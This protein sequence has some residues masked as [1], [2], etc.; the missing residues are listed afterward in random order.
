MSRLRVYASAAMLYLA[1]SI[2]LWWGVWTS[3]PSTVTTCGC[4]D[5]A[6][7]LW[8]F[9]WPA[10]A[11]T[12]G[13]SLWFSP[14]LFHPGGINL[15]ND[16]SVLALSVVLTP[17]T[18]LFGPVAAMNVALA[19]APVVSAL[20]MMVLLRRWVTWT[21]A[22]VLGGLLYGFSP[23][24]ITELAYNQLNIGFLAIP[25]LL[26]VA[27]DELLVRQRRSPYLMGA[28]IAGLA[29]VQFFVS[30]EVL[31]IT[32]IAALVVAVLR[33]GWSA[34]GKTASW[35]PRA[36]YAL[37]G[38]ATALVISVAVLA[39]PAWYLLQGP[40]HLTGPIWSNGAIDQFGNSFTSFWIPSGSG[41]LSSQMLRFGGYQGAPLPG[42]G[43]LGG[44]VVAIAVIGAV[45]WRHDRRILLFAGLGVAATALS[46]GPG[47]GH[48][49]PWSVARH[50]PWVGNI[51][52]V[53]FS[54]VTSLCLAVVVALA[55]D[56]SRTWVATRRQPR[57]A[58]RN[59]FGG[60]SVATVTVA[61]VGLASLIPSLVAL[62]PNLPLTT[63]AVVLPDWYQNVG[64]HLPPGQ[65]VLSY[66]APFAGVQ[67]SMAWQA[68][69]HMSYAMAGG[70]GPEGVANRAGGAEAGFEV[71]FGASL[72]LGPPPGPSA[73][74]LAAIRQALTTWQVTMVVVPDQPGLPSYDQGRSPAYAVGLMTAALGRPPHLDHSAWVWSSVGTRTPP[75]AIP[76]GA[77][78][79]EAC[80]TGPAAGS[81]SA[82][83]RRAVVDCV[84]AAAA[85]AGAATGA[86]S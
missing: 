18:L 67:S 78:R 44:G 50:V 1:M 73:A 63:R 42:L 11:F 81:A 30:T 23:F 60:T 32:A 28:A 52:E 57:A 35:R 33:L 61:I 3:H 6:R 24:M 25:P 85:A 75:P 41:P 45:I 34:V 9:E 83:A 62:W 19:L 7:F 68:V 80:T 47:D 26:A 77:G 64:A 69:N 38:S 55:I 13:H 46:L 10:F 65:V 56:K 86:A 84:L 29:V 40:A 21:P 76:M 74:N 12:N 72:A 22:A 54:L 70:G 48:W 58:S 82:T 31:L 16:T 37:R 43:Y 53:R 2:G 15:L 59:W 8:F 39:Y 66:P 51:V 79:F 20:A 71:L 27:L 36:G 14:W 17:F 4:G 5:A 49:V